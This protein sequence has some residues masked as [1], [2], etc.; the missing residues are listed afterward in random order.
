VHV[1]VPLWPRALV[2]SGTQRILETVRDSFR[3]LL[4][5]VRLLRLQAMSQQVVQVQRS[6][7]NRE[8]S[9]SAVA[10]VVER[11]T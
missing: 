3:M 6:L 10:V 9:A 5:S 4:G 8:R 11:P 7:T 2:I 1:S